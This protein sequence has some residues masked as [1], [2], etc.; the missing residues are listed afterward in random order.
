MHFKGVHDEVGHP[1]KD[2]IVWLARQRF[3]WP[4]LE[5]DIC[6]RVESCGRCIRRKNLAR[7]CAELKPVHTTGPMQLVCMD[8]L[9]LE[10]SKG[11]YENI[12]VI[13]DHFTRYAK[14]I[15]IPE[16]KLLRRPPK[17]CAK[18][19]LLTSP[20]LSDYI[21]TMAETLKAK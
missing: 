19:S 13:T 7:I 8:F 3:F 2:K 20:F 17:P 5:K 9:S 18:I 1:G 4:G 16:I 10:R 11:G 21:A 14:A 12:L 6:T 15:P